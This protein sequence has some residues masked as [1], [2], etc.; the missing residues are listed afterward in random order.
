MAAFDGN[1]VRPKLTVA[2][3][4]NPLAPNVAIKMVTAGAVLA[5]ALFFDGAASAAKPRVSAQWT[6]YGG[7]ATI[8]PPVVAGQF[9]SG[10]AFSGTGTLKPAVGVGSF[11]TYSYAASTK[12]PRLSGVWTQ[13][14]DFSGGIA[15]PSLNI[16][17]AIFAAP[18]AGSYQAFVVN[19]KTRGPALYDNYNFNSLFKGPDGYYYGCNNSG[20]FRLSGTRDN[21]SQIQAKIV[22]G[23]SDFNKREKKFF[24]YAYLALRS[25]GA[26]EF[27]L[28]VDET[29]RRTYQVEAREGTQGV[30][31]KRRK[32]A[33]GIT[34]RSAQIEIR[35]VD[36]CDFDLQNVELIFELTRRT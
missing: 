6:G 32:L 21:G 3:L 5:A 7:T 35:N 27:T 2:G 22:S 30:H 31:T 4:F 19:T 17:T 29:T 20:I 33:Q 23:L 25:E 36:G 24:P 26:M 1:V 12:L 9:I 15:L 18:L 28:T 14:A 8:A 16:E 13:N 10:G 34:G 11:V